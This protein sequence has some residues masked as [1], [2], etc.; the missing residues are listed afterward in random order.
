[1]QTTNK[2]V[3]L[4]RQVLAASLSIGLATAAFMGLTAPAS[5]AGAHMPQIEEMSWTFAGPFGKFD[6]AQLQRGYKVYKEVCA[7]CH[8]MK[9][10][11]FRTLAQQGGPGFTDEQVKALAATFKVQDGPN[12]QGEMFERAARPSDRFPSPFPN[13]QVARSANNGALPPDLSLIAKARAAPRGFPWFILDGFSLYQESGPDYLHALLNGYKDAPKDAACGD[14][15][16]YNSAFLSGTC[17]AMVKPVSDGQIEYTDGTPT[18]VEQYSKDVAAFLMWAAEPMLEERKST[19][20]KVF[21]FLLVFSGLLYFTK[22]K[23]WSAVSH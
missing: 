17:I 8:S 19:G 20:F 2:S 3:P 6:K 1:M 5:S 13:E 14:G 12:D 16:Y 11:S 22:R 7:A 18:T 10:V 21:L 4:A 15:L 23:V 9:F